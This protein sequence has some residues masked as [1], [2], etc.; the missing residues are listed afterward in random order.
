ML[1][2]DSSG[3]C[4]RELGNGRYRDM[5]LPAKALFKLRVGDNNLVKLV[6]GER[7]DHARNM[8]HHARSMTANL[9][10]D[11]K[12]VQTGPGYWLWS[13]G[14]QARHKTGE[15]N[16]GQYYPGNV[17]MVWSPNVYECNTHFLTKWKRQ[18][19][20]LISI[21]AEKGITWKLTLIQENFLTHGDQEDTFLIS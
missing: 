2:E 20:M 17:R 9:S 14:E 11:L 21:D 1:S 5:F 15:I 8:K 6:F 12:E 16:E 3:C 10:K 13:L 18:L 4:G 19:S 7:E